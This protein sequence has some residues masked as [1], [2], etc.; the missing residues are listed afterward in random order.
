MRSARA[1]RTSAEMVGGMKN[2][3][4]IGAANCAEGRELFQFQL[5]DLAIRLALVRKDMGDSG[6]NP[7]N[8]SCLHFMGHD[9]AI[10]RGH[11][12]LH[13]SRCDDEIRALVHVL[14]SFR[15][16]RETPVISTSARVL[17]SDR[18]RNFLRRLLR[19]L[20]KFHVKHFEGART[21]IVH[22]MRVATRT[23]RAHRQ[24]PWVSGTWGILRVAHLLLRQRTMAQFDCDAVVAM[25]VIESSLVGSESDMRHFDEVIL[26]YD[27]VVRF[28][29]YRDG[30][31]LSGGHS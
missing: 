19:T 23:C 16:R 21:H 7:M 4:T 22:A 8:V 26:K 27:P 13:G 3:N 30:L 9:L 17:A 2:Q 18:S 10:G 28:L 24:L 6:I 31:F 14:R 25:G 20:K 12:E 1:R 11:V 15:A 29:I 5:D